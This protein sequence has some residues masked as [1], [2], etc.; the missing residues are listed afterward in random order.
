MSEPLHLGVAET[1]SLEEATEIGQR[2]ELYGGPIAAALHDV[3]GIGL[4][5]LLGSQA[6]ADDHAAAGR[7]E[8]DHFLAKARAGFSKWWKAK[9]QVTMLNDPSANGV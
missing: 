9:R 8:T 6:V 5:R 2:P 7:S 3:E 4:G 1:G